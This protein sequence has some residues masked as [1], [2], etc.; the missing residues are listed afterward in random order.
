MSGVA[1][2]IHRTVARA[3]VGHESISDRVLV[4]RLKVK[5]RN[6]TLI[7]MYGPTTAATDEKMEMF[8]QDL[9]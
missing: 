9:S 1:I 7:Q 3:L 4:V 8:Y 5:P 2:W 6:I